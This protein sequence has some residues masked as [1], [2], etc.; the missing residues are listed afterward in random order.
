VPVVTVLAQPSAAGGVV[1]VEALGDEV[2]AVDRIVISDGRACAEADD[3]DG[4][5]CEYGLPEP[6]VSG[7]SVGGAVGAAVTVGLGLAQVAASAALSDVR[8]SGR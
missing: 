2:D 8:T 5:A 7:C 3:A 6:V 4:I 1:R